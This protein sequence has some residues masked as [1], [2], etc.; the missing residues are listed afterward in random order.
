MHAY[1]RGFHI[2]RDGTAWCAVGPQ[3][4]DLMASDTGFGD[5][6]ETAVSDLNSVLSR[7]RWWQDKVLPTLKDFTVHGASSPLTSKE[8]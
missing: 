2:F 7:R 8:P 4:I 1:S 3:F 5:T 6:L